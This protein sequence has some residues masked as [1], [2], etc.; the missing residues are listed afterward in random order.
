[1]LPR[2]KIGSMMPNAYAQAAQALARALMPDPF[3][4]AITADHPDESPERYACLAQY[5]LYS[6]HEGEQIGSVTL[7][8]DGSSGAAIWLF[9]QAA[10]VA[11][12][13]EREKERCFSGL[14][15]STGFPN[16]TAIIDFMHP[17]AVQTVAPDTWYLSILGL[18]PHMQGQGLGEQLLRP[19]LE[20]ADRAGA[21]CYLETFTPRNIRFYNRLGFREAARF[22]EPVTRSPYWIML[23]E[24]HPLPRP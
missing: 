20:Q 19:T 1:M 11:Q 16:Y 3:Y 21:A 24:P 13:F 4:L 12:A 9:P 22:D 14:L 8:P 6:L 17:R 18:A 7:P 10:E 15:G 5:F 23:R 2:G